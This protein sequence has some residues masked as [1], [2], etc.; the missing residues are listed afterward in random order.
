MTSRFWN[1][2]TGAYAYTLEPRS[3]TQF[4]YVLIYPRKC[5]GFTFTILF[6]LAPVTGPVDTVNS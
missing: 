1:D 2:E 3:A 6:T 5:Y 4:I